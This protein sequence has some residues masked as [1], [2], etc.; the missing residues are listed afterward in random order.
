MASRFTD[1]SFL[2]SIPM[3]YRQ[4][5]NTENLWLITVTTP[6]AGIR[7]FVAEKYVRTWDNSKQVCLYAGNSQGGPAAEYGFKDSVVE[8][9]YR[10]YILSGRHETDFKYSQFNQA[11]CQ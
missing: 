3:E 6:N 10:D 11:M 1:T 7:Q 5:Y 8:G 2:D 9:G 4:Y